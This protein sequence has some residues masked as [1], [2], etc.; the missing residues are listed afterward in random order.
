MIELKK[1]AQEFDEVYKEFEEAKRINNFHDASDIKS[2][3]YG[4][5]KAMTIILDIN[6]TT[7]TKTDSGLVDS[8]LSKLNY[9]DN[10]N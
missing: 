2:Y 10:V 7:Y 9:I 1:M 8:R 4:L 5:V 6:I 3:M